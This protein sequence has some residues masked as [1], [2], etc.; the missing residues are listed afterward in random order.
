[1]RPVVVL[2]LVTLLADASADPDRTRRSQIETTSII[3]EIVRDFNGLETPKDLKALRFIMLY[4]LEVKRYSKRKRRHEQ[5]L[6]WRRTASE[7][8]NEGFVY[9]DRGGSDLVI[10]YIA[11]CKA[12]GVKARY[13]TLWNEHELHTVAEIALGDSWFIYDVVENDAEPVRGLITRNSGFEG[14]KLWK[15]GRDAWDL[16]LKSFRDRKKLC[17]DVRCEEGGFR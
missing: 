11:L 6:R 17:K 4:N 10:A 2:L 9:N 8:F 5:R 16:G 14:W 13:V 7:I 1:M 15:K 3:E 12:L